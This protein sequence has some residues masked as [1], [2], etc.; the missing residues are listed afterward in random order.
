MLC[1]NRGRPSDPGY[2]TGV[3]STDQALELPSVCIRAPARSN[4]AQHEAKTSTTQGNRNMFHPSY[5]HVSFRQQ[6][7]GLSQSYPCPRCSC[8]ILEPYG[9]TET[10]QC[11]SCLRGFVPLRGGRYLYPSNRLGW[12][13]APTFW[14]DGLRWHWAGT[15]ATA[16]QLFTIVALFVLPLLALNAA[17]FM[18][19]WPDRPDWCTPTLMT[20]LLGL[21]T[22]QTI[23]FLCWDFDFISRRKV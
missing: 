17:M 11:N 6:I 4:F 10:F 5:Q 1:C 23:Y 2:L 8:G 22:I 18:N 3:S 19:V 12:K 20:A 9:L 7:I 16:K 21:L 15:T 13:V 14:W